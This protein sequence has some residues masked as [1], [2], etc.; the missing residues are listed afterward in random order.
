[1]RCSVP[2]VTFFFFSFFFFYLLIPV[3]ACNTTV[4]MAL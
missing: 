2:L 1:M 4:L 3:F